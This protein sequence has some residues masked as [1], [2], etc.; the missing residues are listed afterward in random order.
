MIKI[1]LFIQKSEDFNFSL[2]GGSA[3]INCFFKVI[4]KFGDNKHNKD[5]KK[6]VE[7][8]YFFSIKGGGGK[9][10]MENS[11]T[12]NVFFIETFPQNHS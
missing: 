12:F 6:I 4:A 3:D 2:L 5:I 7:N 9:I 11:L 10:W 1:V 8:K